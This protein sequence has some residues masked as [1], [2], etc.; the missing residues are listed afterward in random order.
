MVI[1]SSSNEK[2]K[3]LKKLLQSK[4]RNIE[5]KFLVEGEHLV[6]EAYKSGNLLEVIIKENNNCNLDV[7]KTIVSD[8]VMKSLSSLSTQVDIIGVC[9]SIK[10]N[11]NLGEKLVL[12][13]NVQDP[14]NVGTIIR[15]SVAFNVDTLVLG[16]GSVDLYNPKVI[17]ST[18]GLLF[19]QNIIEENLKEFI[20]KL[21]SDGYVILGTDVNGGKELKTL[22]KYEKY[23]IIMGN[24]GHG[25]EPAIKELCDEYIYINMNKTCESLNVGVACSIILYQLNE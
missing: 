19:H 10:P 22:P 25:L 4:Y 6:N 1:T 21:K 24:E 9:K 7:D 8:N 13:D 3:S 2:I 16:K 5:G 18:Q 15:S 23:A 12:L 11:N 17:R 20:I 14:G